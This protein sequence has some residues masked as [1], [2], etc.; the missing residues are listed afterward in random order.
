MTVTP[1]STTISDVIRTI[2]KGA[3]L[4]ALCRPLV[5][6]STTLNGNEKVEERY[7]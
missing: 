7:I 3:R 4:R 1:Q 5:L 6:T 2:K